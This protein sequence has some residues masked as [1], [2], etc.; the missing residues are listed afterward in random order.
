MQ[1][2]SRPFDIG[3]L[4]F[5]AVRHNR[6]RILLKRSWPVVAVS[7]LVC[8]WLVYPYIATAVAAKDIKA[9]RYDSAKRWLD[10]LHFHV[11]FEQWKLMFNQAIVSAHTKQYDEASEYFRSAIALAPEGQR[12][13]VRTQAV[14]VGELAGDEA[15][16]RQDY[17]EAI[18]FYTKA[19]A[20]VQA[21]VRCFSQDPERAARLAEKIARAANQQ[22]EKNYQDTTNDQKTV[23]K[24]SQAPSEDQMQ[25][26]DKL[27]Q[28]ARIEDI[29]SNRKN[30]SPDTSVPKPW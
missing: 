21:N 4:D 3:K 24:D 18:R 27:E 14:T 1:K 28:G 16:A 11:M 6:R 29:D 30:N 8:G 15:I 25:E 20:E 13:M 9:A 26:L 23:E 22:Q 17:A 12:C 5:E 19:L 2:D 10:S 7:V